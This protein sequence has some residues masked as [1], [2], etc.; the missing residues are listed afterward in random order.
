MKSIPKLTSPTYIPT[1][2]DILHVRIM[3]MG[4]VEHT[5][6]IPLP[7]VHKTLHFSS[8]FK[9]KTESSGVVVGSYNSGIGNEDGQSVKSNGESTLTITPT[10]DRERDEGLGGKKEKCIN[11]HIYDVG[12][13]RGQRHAWASF[14]EGA[15][16]VSVSFLLR[17]C[18][19]IYTLRSLPF[20]PAS[21]PHTCVLYHTVL[22]LLTVLPL[23]S[24][25]CTFSSPTQPR[26]YPPSYI[27]N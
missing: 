20:S 4:V 24:P 19:R 1:D 18:M 3:T 9:R 14:F 7:S 11:M 13:A 10:R 25:T 6:K 23:P 12:G 15:T 8:P 26:P 17:T 5:F 22:L 21:T 16:A 27:P 2:D